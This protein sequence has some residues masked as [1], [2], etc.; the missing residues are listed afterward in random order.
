MVIPLIKTLR[1]PI[2][3]TMGGIKG[4]EQ[5]NATMVTEN[6]SPE[7][8]KIRQKSRRKTIIR[9]VIVNTKR[10]IFTALLL[11]SETSN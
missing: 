11:N 8:L 5:V 2:A 4:G 7:I 1:F 3:L 9:T 6:R 10:N